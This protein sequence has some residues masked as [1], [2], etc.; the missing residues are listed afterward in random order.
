M[1]HNSL[2]DKNCT[3][4]YISNLIGHATSFTLGLY[5]NYNGD[6]DKDE[7]GETTV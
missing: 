6:S 2:F 1:P 5:E 7:D 4:Q 3:I